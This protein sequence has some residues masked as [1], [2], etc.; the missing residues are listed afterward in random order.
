MSAQKKNMFDPA[1]FSEGGLNSVKG[2]E[3]VVV[4][5]AFMVTNW[6][7]KD[8]TIPTYVD[9]KTGQTVSSKPTSIWNIDVKLDDIDDPINLKLSVGNIGVPSKDNIL[10]AKDLEGDF[11]VNPKGGEFELNK[12]TAAAFLLE[13]LGNA[14]FDF[15]LFME[16][17]AKVI[18]GYRFAFD[19]Q[20]RK[21]PKTGKDIGKKETP[22][23]TKI[24]HGAGAVQGQKAAPAPKPA[25]TP[26]AGNGPAALDYA[27]L[28]AELISEVLSETSP[29]AK[30]QVSV[31]VNTKL[32]GRGLSNEDRLKTLRAATSDEVL[33]SGPWSFDKTSLTAL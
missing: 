26:K 32:Q 12:N 27:V 20:I 17:G 7:K 4:S 2:V 25:A 6:A 16:Q 1:N 30:G 8:G 33:A 23:V 15:G 9:A 22:I 14:S 28:A 21:D 19:E 31:K 24:I 5:S 11:L 3:G 18:I 10:P 29:L 13:S